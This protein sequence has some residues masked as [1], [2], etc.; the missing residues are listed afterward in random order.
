LLDVKIY[1]ME[2]NT[3]LILLI[4]I[5]TI[6][7]AQQP[8]PI[9]LLKLKATH[10]SYASSG[11]VNI[12]IP[13]VPDK[14]NS[15]PVINNPPP[16]QIDDYGVW[17]LE[18]DFSVK[19]GILTIGHDGGSGKNETWAEDSWGITIEA[20]LRK[21]KETRAFK[22]KY[23]PIFIRFGKKCWGDNGQ[24][25][26]TSDPNNWFQK[27]KTI[28]I[29]VY[30]RD[31]IFGK[32]ELDS[33]EWLTIKDLGGKIIPWVG[34]EYECSL[35]RQGE[36]LNLNFRPPYIDDML[37]WNDPVN[38][39]VLK[40]GDNKSPQLRRDSINATYRHNTLISQDLYQFDW[41]FE[42]TA[43]P[44]PIYV[45][46]NAPETYTIV[47]IFG[48]ECSDG[49]DRG[50][51]FI[52]HQQGTFKL[53]YDKVQESVDRAYPGWTILMKAGNYNEK[54]T[55]RKT[56]TLKADGGTVIIGR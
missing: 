30:G 23:R 16:E 51:P 37:F 14:G 41:T 21:I 12:P 13:F 24:L 55:I 42:E 35:S 48:D 50:D 10:N 38:R 54:L 53:P 2:K 3:L 29:N 31:N 27:L 26:P 9:N 32:K 18:L 47:N 56:L 7:N 39:A 36:L 11:H 25:I 22:E 49:T 15:C 52:V 8:Q 5:I 4:F 17:A 40:D 19:N 34:L 43:P 20:Y 44:N 46:Q 28:L 33:L 1:N 6:L 45:V